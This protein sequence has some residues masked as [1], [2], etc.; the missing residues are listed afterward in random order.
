[1][2][3]TMTQFIKL[4]FTSI[5]LLT[6]GNIYAATYSVQLD[7]NPVLLSDSF[8]LTYTA[9]GSID[10]EPDFSPIA[11]NFDILG[12]RQSSN[13]S[14]INGDF[15]R[16][17]KWTLTLRAKHSGTFIIPAITFGNEKAPEVEV[18]V[19]D[20]PVS[21]VTNPTQNFLV[22]LEASKK[23][24]FIQEQVLITARLLIAQN[25]SSYQFSELRID[26]TDTI[27]HPI[28]KDKQYKTY[29]GTKPYI[30]IE[31]KFA[32][33]PQH[34]GK[35]RIDPF[36]AEIGIVRQNSR[37]N[38]FDPFNQNTSS[39]RIQSNSIN[40]HVKDKPSS[41]KGDNWIPTT[42]LKLI[43]DW[44]HNTAFN[45]GE[46]ITRTITLMADGLSSV[47]LPELAQK[48]IDNL[49]QY[50][51]KPVLQDS[52]TT[53][54]I[55]SIRKEKIALIPT[56]AGTYTLPA[57][58]I[59]WWNTKTNKIDIAHISKREFTVLASSSTNTNQP[60]ITQKQIQNQKPFTASPILP[61]QKSSL[62]EKT[63]ATDAKSNPIWLW[64]SLLFLVLWVLTLLLLWRSKKSKSKQTY[65]THIHNQSIATRLKYLKAACAKNDSREIKT[66]LL[67][68]A[69]EL[70]IDKEIN[71]L[72]DLA[73]ILGEP[74]KGN[75]LALNSNL[76]STTKTEWHC[77]ELYKLC[78]DFKVKSNGNENMKNSAELESLTKT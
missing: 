32:I 54:G 38:L 57:I 69:N 11:T 10:D 16:N 12:T 60:S 19:K 76:Y 78:C 34:A 64:L 44:P 56:Q 1:M 66:A 61:D 77:S 21:S 36:V 53:K 63:A 6:A 65:K 18:I 25:I 23:T 62:P 28:G 30:I 33:F 72:S 75:I 74:I 39:K 67:Q 59:P 3:S 2:G 50:P 13:M 68:W 47:Q 9:E 71:N 27:I 17:K 48:T 31:K 20:L 22:E 49:K 58:D 5:L 15:K 35:L 51:D 29:R 41:F 37:G 40:L 7:V 70:F 4:F 55:S 42:S 45:V 46:P 43:E 24:S 14:M 73:D 26:D 8:Q 52:K